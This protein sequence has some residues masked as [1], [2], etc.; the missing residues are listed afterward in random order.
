MASGVTHCAQGRRDVAR[1]GAVILA[2]KSKDS[3]FL[4]VV[5]SRR[6]AVDS[7]TPGS[8]VPCTTPARAPGEGAP[9]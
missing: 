7:L 9:R 4:T 6:K 3:V 2:G 5:A 8:L 1:V